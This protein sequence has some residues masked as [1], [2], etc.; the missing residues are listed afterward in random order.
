MLPSNYDD[1]Y[2]VYE[3]NNTHLDFLHQLHQGL[4]SWKISSE[5]EHLGKHTGGPGLYS[6]CNKHQKQNYKD[7]KD[8]TL[9]TL[10]T[11]TT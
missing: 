10:V 9:V 8:L 7:N 6:K 4:L 3:A 2:Y 1:R 11:S 5:A